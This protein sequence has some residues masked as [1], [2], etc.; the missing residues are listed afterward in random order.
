MS[1]YTPRHFEMNDDEAIARVLDTFGF[2]TLVTI[3]H[4]AEPT[5]S[6]VPVLFDHQAGPKGTVI[7]HVAAANPHAALLASGRSFLIFHGPS[8]YVSPNWYE[9]PAANVPTWNYVA[10]HAHGSMMRVDEPADKRV[11]VDTLSARHEASFPRP[12][13]LDKMDPSHLD[14]LL[15]AIVGFE[16]TIE[17]LDAKFKLGQNRSAADRAGVVAGL[18]QRGS[19]GE[20]LLAEWM[21]AYAS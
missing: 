1:V 7:G 12:W 9:K 8:G 15:G 10:V 19:A 4:P 6:H 18:E 3:S 5:V 21:R 16:M 13:T 17:R 2:A 20:Q 11:I 14:K